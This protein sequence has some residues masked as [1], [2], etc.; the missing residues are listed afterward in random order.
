MWNGDYQCKLTPNPLLTNHKSTTDN[1]LNLL[2]SLKHPEKTLLPRKPAGTLNFSPRKAV[3]K[4]F[5]G[6]QGGGENSEGRQQGRGQ[7]TV[8]W[9]VV[10]NIF[11]VH[12]YLGRFPFWLIFFRWVET[13][14]QVMVNRD[15][16]SQIFTDMVKPFGKHNYGKNQAWRWLFGGN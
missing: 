16:I 4:V 10:S 14:N 12:P 8:I 2:K 1:L 11:Y 13:T 15:M 5:P 3:S 7:G 6:R 9:V